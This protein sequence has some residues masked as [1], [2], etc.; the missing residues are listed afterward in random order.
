MVLFY[1]QLLF[2]ATAYRDYLQTHPNGVFGGADLLSSVSALYA[3]LKLPLRGFLGFIALAASSPSS[4]WGA[5]S[6]HAGLAPLALGAANMLSNGEKNIAPHDAIAAATTEQKASIVESLLPQL[7]EAF[8]A[9]APSATATA[10]PTA[11]T[12][13]V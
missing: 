1:L 6:E 10:A 5:L 9:S 2:S 7:L 3:R 13:P 12:P 4:G 11:A 8:A